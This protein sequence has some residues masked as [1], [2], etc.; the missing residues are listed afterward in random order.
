MQGQSRVVAS[1]AAIYPE[2]NAIQADA[3]GHTVRPAEV[4]APVIRTEVVP[5]KV[6]L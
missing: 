1:S 3:C 5:G 4:A 2:I 6:A